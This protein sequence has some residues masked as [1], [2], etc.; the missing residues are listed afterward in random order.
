[1]TARTHQARRLESALHEES[2]GSKIERR[3][4]VEGREAVNHLG[5]IS[6][7]P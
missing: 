7:L 1:V 2:S 3:W 4:I 6:S 5:P